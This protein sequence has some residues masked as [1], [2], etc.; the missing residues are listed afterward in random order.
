MFVF[1]VPCTDSW[2]LRSSTLTYPALLTYLTTSRRALSSCQSGSL[3]VWH[4]LKA[5]FLH[6]K[7]E[8]S[9]R[10]VTAWMLLCVCNSW[11]L[12]MSRDAP[13]IMH[14]G[15]ANPS[16][17]ER[18]ICFIER[19][20]SSSPNRHCHAQLHDLQSRVKQAGTQRSSTAHEANQRRREQFYCVCAALPRP[21]L[22]ERVCVCVSTPTKEKE[23]EK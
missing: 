15:D 7:D 17:S 4:P 11:Q 22:T 10:A 16:V 3:P 21:E 6:V 8:G 13:D 2:C 20:P 12:E 5:C 19:D 9:R 1:P 14:S 18:L 23:D